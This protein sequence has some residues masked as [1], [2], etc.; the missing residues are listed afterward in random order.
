MDIQI[1]EGSV[2][3]AHVYEPI[4][5]FS[6][7]RFSLVLES[8][9]VDPGLLEYVTF[10]EGEPD[11]IKL[12]T[13]IRPMIVP[14]KEARLDLKTLL[15]CAD[16]SNMPRD[17]LLAGTVVR[18]AVKPISYQRT[19]PGNMIRASSSMKVRRLELS[20]IEADPDAMTKRYD[21]LCREAFGQSW[22]EM[23]LQRQREEGWE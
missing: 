7:A 19:R 10:V 2:K 21:D 3:F 6:D 15:Q 17:K 14:R 8:P 13:L 5:K 23:I 12:H 1:I 11:Q 18:V 22:P 9:I 4:G 20:G 16:D